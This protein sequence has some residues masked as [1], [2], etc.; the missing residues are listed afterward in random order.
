MLAKGD[1]KS[2]LDP[3]LEGGDFDINTVW[4]VVEISMACA[5]KTSTNRPTMSGVAVELKE[6]LTKKITGKD[7]HVEAEYSK[8]LE[9]MISKNVISEFSPVAR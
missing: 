7:G 5:S 1:I 4:K 3:N 8:D 2:I 6:C 9:E